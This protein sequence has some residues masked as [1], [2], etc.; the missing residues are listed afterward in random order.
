MGRSELFCTLIIL[1]YCLAYN[2]KLKDPGALRSGKEFVLQHISIGSLAAFQ[3]F[4]GFA[5]E[6]YAK[7]F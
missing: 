4:E 2:M 5:L 1:C 3:S 6:V 7:S